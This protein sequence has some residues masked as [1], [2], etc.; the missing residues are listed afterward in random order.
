MSETILVKSSGLFDSTIVSNAFI[1][2]YMP[3]APEDA[4]KVYF[5]GLM[6]VS[7]GGGSAEIADA[8]SLSEEQVSDAFRYWEK[9]GLVKIVTG[10]N[11][12]M[13]VQYM[14]VFSAVQEVGFSARRYGSLL[15]KLR[16]VIGTRN[17]TGA[18]L[19]KIIDWIE[20]FGFEEDAAVEVV[21]YCLSV[22]GAKVHINYIDAVA[23][24]LAADGIV[25]A[26]DVRESFKKQRELSSG[27]AAILKRWNYKRLPTDDEIALYEKWTIEWGFSE[28]ALDL[29][30]SEM[31]AVDRP[32]FKYLDAILASYHSSGSV[33]ADRIREV[34]HEQDMIAELARQ[35]FQR[36]G[37]KRKA[38][39]SDRAQFELWHRD[40]G[41]SAELLLYA[42][43][44]ASSKPSPFAEMKRII[45]DWHARGIA[46]FRAA[47][48][49]HEKADEQRTQSSVK[50][51]PVSRALNYKQRKYTAE[52]LKK[53]GVDLGEG[54]YDDED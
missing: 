19:A 28:D 32:N 41:M 18:E 33:T 26:A 23:K 45:A 31:V 9:A 21:A 13:A 15:D 17:F 25:T 8:L 46:S 53:L 1:V 16:S 35:C 43:E 11:G 34:M 52:E 48:D 42:A 39:V 38:S 50:G 2:Q 14:P 10:E 54:I 27:A 12:N 37:L 7:S 6:L 36:A 49:D 5:Y 40:W 29:A 20:I 22:K 44:L 4:L 24:R 30:L 51:K 47:K 3:D